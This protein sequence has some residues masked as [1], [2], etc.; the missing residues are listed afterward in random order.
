MLLLVR[1]G[2]APDPPADSWIRWLGWLVK[3]VLTVLWLSRLL[4]LGLSRLLWVS[5]VVANSKK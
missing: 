3:G 1:A 5:A 4:G 2:W